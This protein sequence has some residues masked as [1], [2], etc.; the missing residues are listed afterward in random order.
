MF[1]VDFILQHD[2]FPHH[3]EHERAVKRSSDGHI[4]CTCKGVCKNKLCG[5]R[6]VG[7]KCSKEC[8]CN[9]SACQNQ[10]QVILCYYFFLLLM[11]KLPHQVGSLYP[12]HSMSS[13]SV[14]IYGLQVQRLAANIFH[15]QF[16]TANKGWYS[17]LVVR[18]GLTVPHCKE[19]SMLWNTTLVL[20]LGCIL[21]DSSEH[22]K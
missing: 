2:R 19:P 15:K 7:S 10:D 6:K 17:I 8:K 18:W 1:M 21:F 3:P 4:R 12:R 11:Y 22:G 14:Q 5:C 13:G 9:H 16:Q 20:G